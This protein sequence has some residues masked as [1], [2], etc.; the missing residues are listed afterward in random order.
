MNKFLTSRLLPVGNLVILMTVMICASLM[1]G[2]V[3]AAAKTQSNG[4]AGKHI[5]YINDFHIAFV[6]EGRDESQPVVEAV[7]SG[8]E[9]EVISVN[10]KYTKIKTAAGN[11]GWILNRDLRDDPVASTQLL[12]AQK[13]IALL[14][15]KL[16]QKEQ[17]LAAVNQGHNDLRKR[18]EGMET[19]LH[20]LESDN[21]NVRDLASDPLKLAQLNKDL[22]TQSHEL[23]DKM[24]VLKMKMEELKDDTENRWFL[25][26]AGVVFMSLLI[27]LMMPK[28]NS[29]KS[30][31]G[32]A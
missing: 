16:E 15:S 9:V 10:N 30:S 24:R 32:W 31:G 22:A 29:R 14:E 17:E 4:N 20:R 1:A 12:Q 7:S 2:S 25:T 13:K 8:S 27:G 19:K 5:K 3:F 23:E 21:R 28:F 6:R 11:V 18:F 26:G